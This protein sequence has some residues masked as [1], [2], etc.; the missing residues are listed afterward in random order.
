MGCLPRPCRILLAKREAIVA[1]LVF[2]YVGLVC[3]AEEAWCL[4]IL[5]ASLNGGRIRRREQRI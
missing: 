4:L 1:R 5:T 3:F 2:V